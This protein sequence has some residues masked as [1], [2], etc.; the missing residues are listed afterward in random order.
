MMKL[1][2]LP[3][4]NQLLEYGQS[5]GLDVADNLDRWPT[6]KCTWRQIENLAFQAA[7]G[8]PQQ[9]L[10]M[11]NVAEKRFLDMSPADRK[12]YLQCRHLGGNPHALTAL[13]CY[14]K[15]DEEKGDGE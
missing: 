12:I 14:L 11:W 3:T 9:P 10:N 8:I 13:Q 5:L 2:A 1:I 6:S 7:E 4:R 15:K